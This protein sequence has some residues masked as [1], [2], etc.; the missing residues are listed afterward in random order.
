[1]H[2][3]LPLI[4]GSAR[5]QLRLLTELA[6]LC[7]IKMCNMEVWPF[8]AISTTLCGS[9]MLLSGLRALVTAGQLEAADVRRLSIKGYHC[10]M[11]INPLSFKCFVQAPGHSV[12]S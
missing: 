1:M 9:V 10:A 7:S 4:Q 11:Y 6:L 2:L 3:Q 12:S 8:Q 5:L